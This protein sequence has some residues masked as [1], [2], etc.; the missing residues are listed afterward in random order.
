[1]L[2]LEVKRVYPKLT[3]WPPGASTAN[4]TALL[5]LGAVLCVVSQRVF[6][7]VSV[8]SLSTQSGDFWIQSTQGQR[9]LLAAS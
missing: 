9:S 6:I 2:N 3:D 4:S 1:V 7:V 5:A 8:I